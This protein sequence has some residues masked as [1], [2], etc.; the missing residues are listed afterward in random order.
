MD[1][2]LKLGNQNGGWIIFGT[3]VLAALLTVLPLPEWL[4][5]YRPEWMAL[6]VIYWVIALPDRFG[7]FTAWIAGFFMDVLEGSLLGL[8]ALALAL[9][10]YMALSLYQR[11]RMF[12]PIQQSSTVLILVGI[13]QLLSFWVLTAHSQNTAPNLIFMI[14]ALSSAIVWPFIFHGLRYLRRTFRV[15]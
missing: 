3:F 5:A 6:V 10:A 1:M 14:S 8:N 12:T 7:L 9:V 11:M 4:E 13:H 2:A 15:V